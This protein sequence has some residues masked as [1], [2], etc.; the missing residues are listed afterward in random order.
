MEEEIASINVDKDASMLEYVKVEDI[1]SQT[2]DWYRITQGK[3]P[4]FINVY[5]VGPTIWVVQANDTAG[6]L[7]RAS[8]KTFFL[9]NT[10]PPHGF[11]HELGHILYVT[12]SDYYSND[13]IMGYPE[14]YNAPNCG[15]RYGQGEKANK[16]AEDM[17][18]E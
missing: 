10:A 5:F 2:D 1:Q 12:P 16:S 18:E 17:L 6:G 4:N 11:P 8:Q 9:A 15:V 13:E 14:Y 7:A 3:D